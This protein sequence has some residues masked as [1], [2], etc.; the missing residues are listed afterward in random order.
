MAIPASELMEESKCL[1]GAGGSNA[2]RMIMAL[3]QRI[4]EGGGGGG[5]ENL[6]G[7]GSPVGV[8]TPTAAGQ[9]YTDTTNV[10]LPVLWQATGLT[11]AD[12]LQIT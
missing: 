12:W 2:E 6:L 10:P 3:L 1:C 5:S 9:F 11:D 7:S 4:A 8:V